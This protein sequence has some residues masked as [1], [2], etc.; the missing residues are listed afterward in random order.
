[1]RLKL[2]F[3]LLS[4]LSVNLSSAQTADLQDYSWSNKWDN[5]F[6][7]MRNNDIPDFHCGYDDWIQYSP[8]AAMLIM[9]ACRVES[10]SDWGRM[11][12]AD[13]FSVAFMAAMVNGIKYSAQRMRPDGTSRNSFP[14][15]HTATA[16]MCATML[17]K[18]YGNLSPWISFGGYAVAS[19][20]G[21]SR[22]M[23]NRHWC[24]DVIAG[25]AIGIASVE[26][27]YLVNDAIFKDRH[28]GG[29]WEPAVFNEDKSLKYWSLEAIFGYRIG[30]GDFS[31]SGAT[32]SCQADFPVLPRLGVRARTGISSLQRGDYPESCNF[33]DGLAGAVFN[34]PFAKVL[35]VEA[36]ALLGAGGTSG[37]CPESIRPAAGPLCGELSCGAALGVRLGC[38]FRIKILA[39]YN[40]LFPRNSHSALVGF[41]GS[42]FW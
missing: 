14:S 42:F 9:K 29:R 41:G 34:Y 1:M 7:T 10:R 6:R 39:E 20:T 11:L 12:S 18:E 2:I 8:A 35:S 25:A 31:L 40:L 33:Y 37:D 13:A 3:A 4:V 22:M 21:V 24:T 23:N 30:G 28:R 19:F 26:L 5:G 16:F 17:H 27:A 36:D 15:G 38:N 32:M